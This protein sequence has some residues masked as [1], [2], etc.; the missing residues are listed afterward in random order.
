MIR[1]VHGLPIAAGARA[2][3]RRQSSVTPPVS[4]ERPQPT[5]VHRGGVTLVLNGEDGSVRYAVYK[6]LSSKGR[7]EAQRAF[8]DRWRAAY[9]EPYADE[10]R[11]LRAD[12]S[13]VHRGF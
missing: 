4:P 6:R 2:A 7:M 13:L 1:N 9:Y 10:T 5:F 12:L 3:I 8:W 11:P